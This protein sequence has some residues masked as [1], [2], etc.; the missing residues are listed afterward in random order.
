MLSMMPNM[1]TEGVNIGEV[2][3]KL[4]NI[5]ILSCEKPDIIAKLKKET[6]F[7]SQMCI[8]DRCACEGLLYLLKTLM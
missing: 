2:A 5:Q 7:I 6:A 8:R 4:D 1:K 3:S